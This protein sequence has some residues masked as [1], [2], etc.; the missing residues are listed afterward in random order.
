MNNTMIRRRVNNINI[1]K[2][3]IEYIVLLLDQGSAWYTCEG[4][5][6]YSSQ[7]LQLELLKTSCGTPFWL[8]P[9]VALV[10]TPLLLPSAAL[11]AP[12]LL[13][14]SAALVA[15]PSLVLPA[16]LV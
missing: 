13:L 1:N 12:S 15:S 3:M 9:S 7:G 6:W 5:K 10:A 11:V 16:A 8:V 14:P 4:C 2:G